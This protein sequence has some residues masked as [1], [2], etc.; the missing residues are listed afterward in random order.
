MFNPQKPFNQLPLLPT[1]FNYDQVEILKQVNEANI[2]VANLNIRAE[3]L[4]NSLLLVSP[5]LVRESVASS[6][7]ENINTTVPEVLEAEVFAD[8][9]QGP[10]KEVLF[11]KTA[12]QKGLALVAKHKFLSTNHFVDLQAIIEPTK[13]GIRKSPVTIK[14]DNTGE[15]LYTPPDN[16]KIIRDLLK[17][18][19]DFINN[20]DDTIDP[21]V[22]MAVF[23]YQFEAIHP[24]LDG[25]GRVGRILMILY[26][27]MSGRLQFPVLFLSGYI[28][29]HKS[30][31]YKLLNQCS[32]T[33]DFKDFILYMLTAVREQAEQTEETVIQIEKLMDKHQHTIEKELKV[34]ARDLVSCMF[35]QPFLTIDYLQE[36]LGLASR[37]TASKYLQQLVELGLLTEEK[38]H[39]SKFFYSKQFIK[40]LS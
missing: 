21:L 24:F 15:V 32:Q 5:L 22:K 2:A 35:G 26:L 6:G 31:Y 30:Q 38:V 3:R 8:K 19:E 17:N 20:H 28:Q 33:G 27:V 13:T 18:L 11:Y 23:H 10:A 7:I 39:R 36:Q 4:P 1:K 9:R 40:L 14:N 37:Q 25:N 29:K 34:N 12:M 16:E